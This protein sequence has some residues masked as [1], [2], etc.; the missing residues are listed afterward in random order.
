LVLL[1]PPDLHVVYLCT[2]ATGSVRVS[3]SPPHVLYD[4]GN[5]TD[6]HNHFYVPITLQG[7]H[8]SKSIEAMLDSGVQG[9]F[10]HPRFV[11]ENNI[12]TI[13]LKKPI[14]LGNID[15]SPNRS[16]SITHYAILK[17]LVN[18]H[19]T[20]SLFHIANIGSEDAILGIDWLRRHN[21]SVDWSTDSISFPLCPSCL[22]QKP[23]LGKVETPLGPSV[24]NPD[25][26]SDPGASPPMFRISANRRTR[27]VW[28]NDRLLTSQTD[29]MWCAAGYTYSQ[30]I[31]EEAS[32]GKALRTLDKIVPEHYRD[33]SKVF[34]E[35]E[36][37]RLPTHKAYD[38]V[39]DLKPDAPESLRSKVYPMPVN[40]QA[41]LDRFLE[42][43]LKKGY[44]VP[45]KSP[46]SSPVFFIKK[47]DGKLCLI[48]DYRKLNDISIKN[49]YPLP[50]ASDI[51]NQLRGARYFTKFD[52]RWGY[53]N[54]RIKEGDEWKAVFA[55][56]RGLFE[57]TVMFFG[58]T[59]SPATFQGMM[60]TIFANLVAEGKVAVY[61]DDILIFTLDLE[62]H[63][64]VVHKVLKHL[65]DNDLY[66]RP[67]KCDFEKTKVE[68][69]GMV[70][71][72]GQVC[73]DPAKVAAVKTWA[74]PKN[75]CDVRVF[76][77]FANF[78]RR[79]IK[80][81]AAITRPLHNLTKKDAPWRWTWVEKKAFQMLKDAFISEPI[82]AMW[83]PAWLT[84]LETNASAHTIS[85][86]IS[87]CCDDGLYHPVAFRS[88]SL[89]GAERNYNTHN[90]EMYA[91]I[92]ALED[93]RHF[94]EGLPETFE[95][96]TDHA[97]LQ[98]WTKAQN[99]TRRQARW[100]LWLS[101]FH[102]TLTHKPGKLNVLANAL[103]RLPDSE[104]HDSEDNRNVTVLKPEYF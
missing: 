84:R 71:L 45:S 18:G 26:E 24:G 87:Q 37:N 42:E 9:C 70:I 7:A 50:L 38:H 65:C 40:K 3:A 22:A 33:F 63:R 34:S 28:W 5:T 47:K 29:E 69:L 78:Y 74:Q 48:Q 44:I 96:W 83:D 20:W 53:N 55:T 4:L 58:M 59:N 99:L 95:I 68:Y 89:T 60:N 92:R 10:M 93:W 54:V 35:E 43:N 51:I 13:A 76:I 46:M 36:S 8:R 56:N 62:E 102:F 27:S 85:G 91:I 17:V 11:K 103:S 39:I 16:G 41:E 21:P 64:R 2:T 79:F 67:E 1:S 86:M 101:R 12:T 49:H 94:L 98:Y 15:G 31:A 81:F 52:I 30:Q 100:A 6:I 72:E 32:K 90:H 104:V 88:K 80:D 82:L 19:L 25:V 97:N 61:L 73:M 14:G 23:M 57:P 75:L 66:L 77:G